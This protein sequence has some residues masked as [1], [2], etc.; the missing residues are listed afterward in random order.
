LPLFKSHYSIGKSILTL[1]NVETEPDEA[2]SVFNICKDNGLDQVVVTDDNMS[3]F[4]EAYTNSKENN[5]NLIFGMRLTVC[6]DMYQKDADSLK[7]NNKI[8]IFIKNE[9]GY[10][11]LIK[12]FSL[13]SRKG[14][15]YEPR[16]DYKNLKDNWDEESLSLAIPFYDSYIFNNTLFSSICVPEFEF[17]KPVYFIEDNDLPFDEI[18]KN[19]TENQARVEGRETQKTQSIYY[20]QKKDFKAYLTFRCINN[21]STLDKPQLDHMTSDEF[22][23]ESWKEK[24]RAYEGGHH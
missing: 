1:A 4:L 24:C 18:I 8:L 9:E 2:D 16:I 21:R 15:Y 22:C 7:T 12:I 13:A 17:S 5:I 20:N 11:R 19:K 6:S 14:F 23:F 3:G 10:K